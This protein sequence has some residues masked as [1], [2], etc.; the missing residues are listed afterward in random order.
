MFSGFCSAAHSMLC[1]ALP[2]MPCSTKDASI[3]PTSM[4]NHIPDSAYFLG[5]FI[6]VLLAYGG[7]TPAI[8]QTP[9][10]LAKQN[11]I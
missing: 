1:S 9:G 10:T 6:S 4:S 7:D 8:V 11:L 3:L 5:S 2:A